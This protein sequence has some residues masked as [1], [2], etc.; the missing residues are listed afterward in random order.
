[1]ESFINRHGT[2][3]ERSQLYARAVNFRIGTSAGPAKP[4]WSLL[5]VNHMQMELPSPP[6]FNSR[7]R[8]S[9]AYLLPHHRDQFEAW[10]NVYSVSTSHTDSPHQPW[11]TRTML[12]SQSLT[13]SMSRKTASSA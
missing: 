11:P 6:V 10:F 7:R 13:A 3:I 9:L 2:L 8:R 5:T 12:S 1:M 4:P